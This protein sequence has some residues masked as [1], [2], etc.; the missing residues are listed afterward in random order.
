MIGGYC[1]KH[2]RFRLHGEGL[3]LGKFFCRNFFRGCDSEVAEGVK[4]CA[5]CLA[6]NKEGKTACAHEGCNFQ[7]KAD[8]TYCGKH[9]RDKI[10]EEAKTKGIRYCDIARGCMKI[11]DKDAVKCEACLEVARRNEKVRFDE[12]VKVANGIRSVA[13]TTKRLCIMCGKEYEKFN[14]IRGAESTRCEG[15]QNTMRLQDH[16]R[17][18][19]VR[20]YKVEYMNN[21]E[22]YYKQYYMGAHKREHPFEL[23]LDQFRDLVAKPCHYCNHQKEGEANG[24]DRVDNDKGYILS[25]CVSCCDVCNR[26][27]HI[28]HIDFFLSKIK[29]IT[30][31]TAPSSEFTVRWKAYYPR[32]ATPYNKYKYDSA[33]RN[34]P[35]TLTEAQYTELTHNPCYL[36]GYSN[37]DGIG[38]DRMDNTVRSY[39]YENCRSC[40]HSCNIMKATESHSEFLA[41]CAAIATQHKN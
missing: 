8:D 24:I 36:C 2:Q 40:C 13:D 6:K 17:E 19:R 18:G 23:T 38:I 39:T 32:K 27:K 11:L 33:K 25:N 10:R 28:Y 30:T 15:C 29:Q 3:A 7:A 20:S 22:R 26:M 37:T 41:Q 12:R 35:L 34:V 4:T 1:Q 31:H 21:I 14:T 9:Q 5:G 16:K